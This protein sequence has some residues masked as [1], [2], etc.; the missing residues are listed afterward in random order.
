MDYDYIIVGSGGAG[1]YTALLARQHGRVLVVTKDGRTEGNTNYAQGGIAAAMGPDDSPDQ[2]FSDTLVAGAGLCDVHAV[3]VLVDEG[4]ARMRDLIALGMPFDR[5]GTQLSLGREGAHG[6]SRILHAGGDATGR[7]LELTLDRVA[8]QRGIE[9]CEHALVTD[10]VTQHGRAAGVRLVDESSSH[11]RTLSARFVILATGGAGR[12]YAH[13]TNPAVA[14]GDGIGLAYCAGAAL[15]GMEFYQFHPT[16][17]NLPGAPSFLIS[18]A[19]RGAGAILRS[20]SGDAFM[21]RYDPRAELAP[22]DIVARAMAAEMATTAQPVFLDLTH[23]PAEDTRSHF[24]TIAAFCQSKGVDITRQPVP[25]APAAHYY[26]GGIATDVWGETTIPNLFAVG[27]CASSGIHG[28]NRLASNSLLELLVFGHRAIARTRATDRQRGDVSSPALPSIPLVL[29]E[30]ATLA[31]TDHTAVASPPTLAMLQNAMWQDAGIVRDAA[32][33][34]RLRQQLATW[35]L[36]L[37]VGGSR[38]ERELSSLMLTGRL[39]VEAALARQESRG[40]H[41]RTD[42]PTTRESWRHH[43]VITRPGASWEI[44]L[45]TEV[46]ESHLVA[47]G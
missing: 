4:P 32:G 42:F 5:N 28:A 47:A 20:A 36:Q 39:L 31:R 3:R 8:Q 25:V 11:E 33:L 16:A 29:P 17:L 45:A 38:S 9:V 24:P 7:H 12:L 23:L 41:A 22:R 1:L 10:I 35:T 26:M 46:Q 27:E 19:V 40:A 37:P 43:Q 18:E 15:T 2:H 6:R 21:V 30:P 44:G 14:T 34:T 13:T